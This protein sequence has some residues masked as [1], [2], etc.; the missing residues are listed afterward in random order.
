MEYKSYTIMS[1]VAE[2]IKK[3]L[4]EEYQMDFWYKEKD[5]NDKDIEGVIVSER[6]SRDSWGITIETEDDQAK[7]YTMDIAIRMKEIE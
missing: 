5:L 2:A 6:G 1:K 4:K 3:T 7:E